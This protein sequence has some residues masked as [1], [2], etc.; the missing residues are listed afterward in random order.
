MVRCTLSFITEINNRRVALTIYS[1]HGSARTAKVQA[2][3]NVRDF[4]QQ[5][6]LYLKSSNLSNGNFTPKEVNRICSLME[7]T[8]NDVNTIG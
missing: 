5:Q 1:I 8:I 4:Y 3:R 6:I 7:T 2:I